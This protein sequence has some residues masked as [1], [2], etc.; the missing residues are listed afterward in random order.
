MD[1]LD[2]DLVRDRM[3]RLP[4][5]RTELR[6]TRLSDAPYV[7][8]VAE[9]PALHEQAFEQLRVAFSNLPRMR[10]M[11]WRRPGLEIPIEEADLDGSGLGHDLTPE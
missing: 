10:A 9:I 7:T 11:I 2:L 5:W 4:D 1:D 8:V 3:A 6:D